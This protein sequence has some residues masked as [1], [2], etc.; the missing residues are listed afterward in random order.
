VGSP[1]GLQLSSEEFVEYLEV[2]VITEQKLELS[3]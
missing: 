1:P 2:V 3:K